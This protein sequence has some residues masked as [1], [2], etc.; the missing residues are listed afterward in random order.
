MGPPFFVCVRTL[1]QPS[2]HV[3]GTVPGATPGT[4]VWFG[5]MTTRTPS[6]RDI[7]TALAQ[8]LPGR[9]FT[10]ITE[11][12]LRE[13]AAAGKA[14]AAS[15]HE[16]WHENA[17]RMGFVL[18]ALRENDPTLSGFQLRVLTGISERTQGRWIDMA[19]K[20]ARGESTQ[21]EDW[22]A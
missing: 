8:L 22:Q 18:I 9:T 21:S 1:T 11:E 4:C 14:A 6:P 2:A 17:V 3:P 20:A 5:R 16:M 12:L 13:A 19:R 15:A 10:E 7:D